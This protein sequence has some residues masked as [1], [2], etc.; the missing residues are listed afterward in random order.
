MRSLCWFVLSIVLLASGHVRVA[1]AQGAIEGGFAVG[2][3]AATL[4]A[5]E[6]EGL[7]YRTVASGGLFA[8]VEAIGPLAVRGEL[9]LS[10]KGVRIDTDQGELTLKANYLELPVLL[11]GDLPLARAYTP[12]LMAGPA[13]GFKLYER[14]GAPGI[15][16][17]TDETA[18]TRTD[19]GVLVGAGAS[20]GGPGALTVEVRYTLGLVD[21]TRRADAPPL[22]ESLPPDGKNGVFSVMLRFSVAGGGQ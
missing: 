3:N 10:P 6:N 12:H 1:A 15:S 8:Q 19:A 9:L 14:R 16:L 13:F 18:F 21:V 22:D 17:R 11:V 7:R 2:V 5:A 4:H 20:L